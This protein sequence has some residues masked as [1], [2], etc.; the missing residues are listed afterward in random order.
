MKFCFWLL[1][2]GVSLSAQP[3]IEWQKSFGGSYY[4][5]ARRSHQTTDGGYVMTGV[6]ISFDGDVFGNHGGRD[7]WVIK[8]SSTGILEWK[9]TYGGSD[10]DSAY[11]IQQTADGG[12]IVCGFTDSSDWGISNFHGI[13]DA[14]VVKLSPSGVVEWQKC[15]G[16]SLYDH[17]Y[18]II[19]TTDGNYVFAG[20]AQSQD[21]DVTGGKG[22]YDVWVVKIDAT[23]NILWQK[24]YGGTE[25]EW[26]SH[27]IQTNDGGF[28]LAGRTDSN[29]GDITQYFGSEDL[30]VLK[31]DA[32]GNLEWQRNYGG[33]G[34][35]V[36]SEIWQTQDGG[37]ITIGYIGTSTTGQVTG[38]H[39]G[40]YDAWVARLNA[41]GDLLWQRAVGGSGLDYGRS[42][43][44]TIDGGFVVAGETGS[45]DGDMIGND[46]GGDIFLIKLNDSGVI[47]WQKTMG[48][49]QAEFGRCVRQT[50]DAGFIVAG[51]SWSSNGD[52]SSNKGSYDFW[53][54]KL[55]PET[56]TATEQSTQNLEVFPNPSTG[57]VTLQIPTEETLLQIQLIDLQG[58]II[59]QQNGA[60]ATFDLSP[61]PKGNYLLMA[62]S[63]NGQ[64]WVGKVQ[65][66]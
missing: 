11:D 20:Y 9:K 55:S 36:A 10:N 57:I 62:R 30:L 56:T 49:S 19:Q 35:E 18:S 65:K 3:T 25:E 54:I 2:F 50:A 37:Y 27:I 6:T 31:L 64:M 4:D 45:I 29:G 22:D 12:Y 46:G 40:V 38:H 63:E 13:R 58:R 41:T 16:G 43:F 61:F 52:A 26:A 53:I 14:W 59:N 33:N 42:I 24:T 5:E 47:Q 7:F 34:S 8:V 1:L 60:D 39:G 32:D 28:I 17:A 44:P 66:G 15:Y 21:G 48:G 51:S 23:G